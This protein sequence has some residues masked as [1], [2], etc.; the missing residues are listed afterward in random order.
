[1]M[2]K[3]GFV[4]A[5]LILPLLILAQSDYNNHFSWSEYL[6][7]PAAPGVKTQFGLA[8][9]FAGN[10]GNAVIVAGGCNFPDIP[11]RD[12]GLKKYYNDVFILLE[13][14]GKAQ[15]KTGFETPYEVA[16]GASV[17]L[18]EGVLCIG[19]KNNHKSFK[20]V[21]LLKWNNESSTLDVENWPELPFAMV[22]FGA[23]LIDE[24]VYVIGGLSDDKLANTFLSL[25]VSKKG[26]D[27]FEWKVLNDF[28]GPARLQ[29]VVVAQNAAEAKHL[30]VF[31][32][33][34]YPENQEKPNVTTDGL[35]FN[36]KTE[37]WT[38]ISEI[39]PKGYRPFSLHGAC[40]V[41]NGINHL[42]F[43]GGV[44]YYFFLDEM[45]KYREREFAKERPLNFLQI[46]L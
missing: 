1:M 22:D 33:S 28:P 18:R 25:D 37:E 29:P 45:V 32:G 38:Q 10:S 39:A 4:L 34:S 14:D 26:T 36:P 23:A 12:G 19:G 43:V 16:Y 17:N 42:L 20:N 44:N 41:P 11:A 6:E 21:F 8:A 40:G 9:P 27:E 3:T 13:E 31:S 7:I 15:W 46:Y 24:T 5:F 2:R 30:F 35:E